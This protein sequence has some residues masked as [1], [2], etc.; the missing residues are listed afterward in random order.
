VLRFDV[1]VRPRGRPDYPTWV[2]AQFQR[3]GLRVD[4]EA[5]ERLV[6]LA[7][8]DA[9]V[10]Q[11]EVEKLAAWAGDDPVGVREVE[12][13]AAP[14]AETSDFALVDAWGARD[15]V[16]VLAASEARLRE[17]EAF[18]VLA[19]LADYVG[20]VRAVHALVERDVG[21]REIAARLGLKEYPARKQAKQA[22]NFTRDELDDAL[23]RLAE[24]DL[25]LK[26][27][28]RLSAELELERALVD[29]TA[30]RRGNPG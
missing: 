27:G 21:V 6:E 8:D 19:R 9:F 26:G 29:V 15:V 30:G 22:E 17:K 13:L 18:I 28:S 24:A 4:Q 10:L 12:L 7:G 20:R 25:A 16:G 1:P 5:A 11:S 14:T 3:A 2:R 23:V